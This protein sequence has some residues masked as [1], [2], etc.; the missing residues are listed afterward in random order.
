MFRIPYLTKLLIIVSFYFFL[1]DK[2]ILQVFLSFYIYYG[3][4]ILTI[5]F[6]KDTESRYGNNHEICLENVSLK[7]DRMILS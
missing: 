4:K 3:M 5:D 1:F 2:A 7:F 6:C